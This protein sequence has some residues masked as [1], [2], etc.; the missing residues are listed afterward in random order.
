[1]S[2]VSIEGYDVSAAVVQI[3]G[4]GAWWLEASTPEALV[5][6]IGQRVTCQVADV[7]LR[8]TVVSGGA[9]DGRSAYRV[10]GGAGGWA[11]DLPAKSYT[12]TPG[13]R[14][15]EVLVDAAS[16]AGETLG[17]LPGTV[18]G[19]HFVREAG[20]AHRVLNGLAPQAWYIDA[21]G[22]TQFGARPAVA[23]T[24]E[25]SIVRRD[26]AVGVVEIET[27]ELAQLVPGVIV[28]GQE[29]ASDVEIVLAGS[30][31]VARVYSAPKMS[32]RLRAWA[33]IFDALDPL[34][35][36]RGTFEYRVV[37][38][39]GEA[40]DLQLVRRSTGLGDLRGV[41]VRLAP[42]VKATWLPGSL[43]LVTFVDADPSRPVVVSGDAPDA[44]GWMPL[45]LELGGPAALGVARMTDAV[46]AGPFS[47]VILGGSLRVKASL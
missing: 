44:P 38:Q 13:V 8:G 40:L 20:P 21:L 18:L 42:G 47:G 3:P 36:F 45:F 32:R 28:D 31:L 6:D 35:K 39:V 46:Q 11:Q 14:V 29:P 4:W 5:L 1:M 15:S 10:V 2:T 30:K 24:G 23:W 9:V 22:V 43:A 26:R 17:P 19:R 25:G 34:R 7:E 12:K 27:D 41:S 33:R 16:E 37:S